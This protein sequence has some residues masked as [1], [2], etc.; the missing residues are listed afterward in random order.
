MKNKSKIILIIC[1]AVVYTFFEA[2]KFSAGIGDLIRE[3]AQQS[4][5]Y[6]THYEAELS[7]GAY[8]AGV[9]FPTG[10]YDI[11]AVKGNG[12]ILKDDWSHD[13]I[14]GPIGVCEEKPYEKQYLNFYISEGCKLNVHSVTIKMKTDKAS[15][16]K[17]V[18]R[19]QPNTKTI[20]LISGDYIAG[21]DFPAGV[22]DV[23]EVSGN[24]SVSCGNAIC[25]ALGP[26]TDESYPKQ[27]KNISFKKGA[28]LSVLS[29]NNDNFQTRD[30]IADLVP[31]K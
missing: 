10:I 30:V 23:V 14:G 24:V 18:T 31:S 4:S 21:T 22:Y 2:S 19:D 20:E 8:T 15:S 27:Y 5:I 7:S 25:A 28:K 3:Q 17:L 11:E 1:V 26:G 9:D 12:F 16:E 13:H 29:I 6:N